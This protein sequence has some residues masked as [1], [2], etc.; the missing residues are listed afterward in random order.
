M[1]QFNTV[2]NGYT[3]SFQL[4]PFTVI[5]YATIAGLAVDVQESGNYAVLAKA[6]SN[7][8]AI[9]IDYQVADGSYTPTSG[10][11]SS[12]GF[13][14]PTT[15]GYAGDSI[16]NMWAGN[17]GLS[18]I[19][20]ARTELYPCDL[21][22]VMESA[23]GGTPSSH[24]LTNQIAILEALSVKP[25][26]L[27]VQTFQNDFMSTEAAADGFLL[28]LTTYVTRAL[29][30][31]VKLI[32]IGSRPPKTQAIAG[33]PQAIT[34]LNNKIAKYC[35]D[36]PGTYYIDVFNSW[37]GV[38]LSTANT[39]ITFRGTPAGVDAF[40]DDGTHPTHRA[41]RAAGN[42]ILPILKQYARPIS[43]FA[44]TLDSYNNSTGIWNNLLGANGNMVG[45]TG[46]LNGVNNTNVAGTGA[47]A[48]TRWAITD[49]NGVTATPAIVTGVDGFQYQ[50]VT[51]SGTATGN[52]GVVISITP[53]NDFVLGNFVSEAI[54]ETEN[55][56]GINYLGLTT[57][58]LPL[59]SVGYPG[60]AALIAPA[61]LTRYHFRTAPQNLQNTTS[62]GKVFS[63]SIEFRNTRVVSGKIRL[64]RIG[65]Y[66]TSV[67]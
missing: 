22:K 59:V 16:G 12:T 14:R 54:V 51:L 27:I 63:L 29:A 19:Q 37:R 33:V 66:R 39:Q 49:G 53:S 65:A 15:I 44:S 32:C 34:Y 61:P 30:A 36:T 1:S 18:G 48:G 57:I 7:G 24:L 67:G 45:T 50:E 60:S 21:I 40:T 35:A 11:V 20:W 42:L 64:G 58:G 52:G 55:L 10:G 46:Q 9:V 4:P 26:I 41:M 6:G 23:A 31:G 17:D 43:P 3:T 2:S 56:T 25:D 62:S 28:N 38:D 8:Q 5:N 13:S 47:S